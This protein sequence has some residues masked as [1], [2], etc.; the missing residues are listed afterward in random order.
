MKDYQ[1]T[2]AQGV[3]VETRVLAGFVVSCPAGEATKL[4]ILR[5]HEKTP[6]RLVVA[7][8]LHGSHSA[9]ALV[10]IFSTIH[11]LRNLSII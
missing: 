7:C 10:V 5:G 8:Q 6:H 11:G 1:L 3:D 2:C 9:V 4:Q